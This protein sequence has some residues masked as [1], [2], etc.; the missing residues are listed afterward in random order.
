MKPAGTPP[1]ERPVFPSQPASIGGSPAEQVRLEAGVSLAQAR[2]TLSEFCLNE[3]GVRG[4]ALVEAV[5]HCGDVPALQRM[6]NLIRN[7]VQSSYP[8]RLPVLVACV[9]EINQTAL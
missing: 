4:Q 7:E 1:L 6:L 5:N 2:F 8:G 3:F 9:L